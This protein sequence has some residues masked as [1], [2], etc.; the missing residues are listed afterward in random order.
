M[1]QLYKVNVSND[2]F[3]KLVITVSVRGLSAVQIFS[4]EEF[5]KLPIP[6]MEEVLHELGRFVRYHKAN[7]KSRRMSNH[8][9]VSLDKVDPRDIG[10]DLVPFKWY[11]PKGLSPEQLE[12]LVGPVFKTD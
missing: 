2:L 3:G 4:A 11:D 1:S 10:W 5:V 12:L 9:K 6:A 7:L 8:T